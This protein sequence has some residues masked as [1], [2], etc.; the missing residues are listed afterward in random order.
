MA[1]TVYYKITSKE[2]IHN[3]FQYKDGLNMLEGE[4]AGEG[5]CV[6]GGLY[7]TNFD[8]IH[9]FYSYG[10]WL[11]EVRLPADN[12]EFKMVKNPPDNWGEKWRANMI[13]LDS[14][15]PLFNIETIKKFNLKITFQYIRYVIEE[16][17]LE[18]LDYVY[19]NHKCEFVEKDDILRY[20]IDSNSFD[21]LKYLHRKYTE[22]DANFK[23]PSCVLECA[24]RRGNYDIIEYLVVVDT[25]LAEN[26]II[27][28][29]NV[30]QKTLDLLTHYYG[31]I[32]I[33]KSEHDLYMHKQRKVNRQRC[34]Q[35]CFNVLGLGIISFVG[36]YIGTMIIIMLK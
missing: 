8:N 4:F 6:P 9:H 21:K 3:E 27:E 18:L 17:D 28:S 2:E 29:W 13:I 30:D 34:I 20:A 33:Y 25:P 36:G 1:E 7:F 19:T 16:G 10:V 32:N 35:D 11:R 24:L 5:S 26:N 23:V 14:K 22:T 31:K 12:K 15:Y